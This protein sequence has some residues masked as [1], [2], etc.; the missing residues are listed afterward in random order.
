MRSIN[1]AIREDLDLYACVHAIR[2]P[3]SCGIGVKPLSR[4]GTARLVRKAIQ[5][6]VA[7]DLQR[8]MPGATLVSCSGFGAAV[9]RYMCL[10]AQS[11]DEQLPAS[12]KP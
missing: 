5:C 1:V 10:P 3:D 7:E 11:V 9:I 6:A 12:L 2:F 4:E 8:I